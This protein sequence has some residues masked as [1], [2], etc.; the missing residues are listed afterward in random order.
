MKRITQE[1]YKKGKGIDWHKFPDCHCEQLQKR[2]EELEKRVEQYKWRMKEERCK[3]EAYRT[4]LEF[5]KKYVSDCNKTTSEGDIA[6]DM[7]A[8]DHGQIATTALQGKEE[9]E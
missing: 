8:K 1:Q 6:R 5:Y 7:L 4:A 9:A 2:V 3:K